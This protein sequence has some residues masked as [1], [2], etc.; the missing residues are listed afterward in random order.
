VGYLL[1]LD[2]TT[3][4]T[5]NVVQLNDPSTGA[6]AWVSDSSTASPVVGPDGDVYYGVLESN[7]PSHNYRGWL[8]H[9]DST[10]SM[11]KTSGSF[12]WDNTPSIVPASMVNSYSGNSS[13]LLL[14]KYNN[15]AGAGTGDGRNRMAILDPNNTEVDPISGNP[16]MN[17]V[18]TLLGQ[19]PDPQAIA[20]GFPNAVK[21]WCVNAAAVDPTTNSVFV[22]SEDGILYR[23]DLATA[24]IS[25]KISLDSGLGQAYTPTAI[26]PDGA[27]YS[28][29]DAILIAVKN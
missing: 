5:K 6:P 20:Q 1:A 22:N 11:N 9:F 12:G 24:Q 8:L 15:Y 18:M 28:I 21:E 3:L 29:N 19:T 17:E 23:W 14:T 27:V 7:A 25:Q 10:L 13:Y 4:A 16:V 26:G 2:A